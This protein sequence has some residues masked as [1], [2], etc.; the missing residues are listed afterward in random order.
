MTAPSLYDAK[1]GRNSSRRETTGFTS[2]SRGASGVR[3]GAMTSDTALLESA[4]FNVLLPTNPVAPNS[5]SFM[6]SPI[7]AFEPIPAAH[8]CDPIK[9]VILVFTLSVN[10]RTQCKLVKE[11]VERQ[12]D[13]E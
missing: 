2:L 9:H 5:N 13:G 6:F 8:R 4:S 11:L 12:S 10:Y 7:Q 1:T 3:V